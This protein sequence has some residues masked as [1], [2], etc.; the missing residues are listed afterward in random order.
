M[1]QSHPNTSMSTGVTRLNLLRIFVIVHEKFAQVNKNSVYPAAH[2]SP[3][4]GR[5]LSTDCIG[6]RPTP[7][8]R[9]MGV[10]FDQVLRTWLN[11]GTEA[12]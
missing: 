8:G 1:F 5:T 9:D 7:N 2:L 10:S 6:P 11:C 12:H 3:P 4:C